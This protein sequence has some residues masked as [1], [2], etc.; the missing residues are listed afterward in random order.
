LKLPFLIGNAACWFV[1]IQ[2]DVSSM[3]VRKSIKKVDGSIQRLQC[4]SKK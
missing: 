1:A 4:L 2:S 3:L